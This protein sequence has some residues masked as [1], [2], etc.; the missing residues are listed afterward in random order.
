MFN[1][2]NYK[3]VLTRASITIQII[4]DTTLYKAMIFSS[5]GNIFNANEE[6]SQLTLSVKKGLEDITDE[7]TDIVWSRFSQNAGQYEE[8]LAWGEQ[9]KGKKTFVLHRDDILEKANIQVAVYSQ[10]DNERTLVAADY[11]SFVDINDMK[12]APIPP[13]NPIHGDIWLDTSVTPPKLMM[14]DDNLKQWV[15]VFMANDRRNLLRNSN[16][17][18]KTFDHWTT[19]G[20]PTLEAKALNNKKWARISCLNNES[21]FNGISQSVKAF[22]K[23][24]YSFQLLGSTYIHS[25]YPN[26]NIKVIIN[27]INNKKEKTKISEETFD[28]TSE[29]KI[30]SFSF[31]TLN[32]T[33]SLEV[34]ITNV[35]N[36]KCDFIFTNVKLER[37]STPTEWEL[38]PEDIEDALNT[39]VENDPDEIFNSLTDN[40]KMEGLYV[41]TD[42]HGNKHFYFNATYIKSGYISGDRIDAKKL[43]VSRND[44]I[45]TLEIDEYGNVIFRG[46]IEIQDAEGFKDP[47]TV[48]DIAYKVE[49]ISS[50]GFVFY[51]GNVSTTLTAKVFRG[52]DD[53]TDTLDASKF[54]WTKILESGIV[55]EAWNQKY[56]L[57]TKVIAISKEDVI[58]K[59]T[60]QC[61]IIK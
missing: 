32:D 31:T 23:D 21:N 37:N 20:T 50:N 35:L 44:G 13:N 39:K 4:D 52:K 22:A 8:D 15:E 56:G 7:F 60:F 61:E 16:F 3:D 5:N 57:N 28:I 1:S 9:H 46:K 49:I 19:I 58:K 24:A 33:S 26:G 17:Y 55:D 30:F 54:K 59:S 42:E 14:W 51:N 47:A 12:G 38:A 41:D 27:S 45:K 11:V 43:T 25:T 48:D 10:I 18:K 29:A 6:T 34:N 2:Y 53:I 36:E 40:G